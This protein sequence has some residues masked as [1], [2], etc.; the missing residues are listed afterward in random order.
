MV[1]PDQDPMA[2]E[3]IDH[4]RLRT[5]GRTTEDVVKTVVALS[6]LVLRNT[7]LIVEAHVRAGLNPARPIEDLGMPVRGYDDFG[8]GSEHLDI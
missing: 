8:M 5:F 3:F 1:K 6:S 4:N 2:M 7:R